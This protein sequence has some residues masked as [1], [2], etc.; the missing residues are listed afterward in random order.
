MTTLRLAK[1]CMFRDRETETEYIGPGTFDVPDDAVDRFLERVQWERFDGFDAADWLD[2]PSAVA[3]KRIRAGQQDDRLEE[4]R[5]AENG[6]EQRVSVYE[7]IRER[8]E[9]RHDKA[10]VKQ[11]STFA[12]PPRVGQLADE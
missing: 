12:P 5:N 6:G 2:V 10:G 3:E 1:P 8:M 11:E 7:A 9:K 4:I